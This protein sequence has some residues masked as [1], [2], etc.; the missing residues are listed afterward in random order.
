[1]K[2]KNMLKIV[3]LI[4]MILLDHSVRA[5]E[6]LSELEE[7]RFRRKS[8][9]KI[10]RGKR[11]GNGQLARPGRVAVTAPKGLPQVNNQQNQPTDNRDYE[12]MLNAKDR[13]LLIL[14]SEV[15][16][17]KPPADKDDGETQVFPQS[18]VAGT[19]FKWSFLWYTLMHFP[20]NNALKSDATYW[21]SEK[22][23]QHDHWEAIF[24]LPQKI[25][26]IEIHWRLAPKRFRVFFKLDDKDEYIPVTDVVQKTSFISKEGQIQDKDSYSPYNAVVFHKPIFAKRIRINLNE[27]IK[28]NSFSIFF[29]KFFQKKTTL[30]IKNELMDENQHWCFYV[31]TNYPIQDTKVE[32]YPCLQALALSNNNELWIHNTDS[33]IR[34]FNSNM[35]L[36]FDVENELVLRPCGVYKPAF[37]VQNRRD[38]TLFF[39]GYEKNCLVMDESKKVSGNFISE[40]TDII[41]TTQADGQTYK[42]ENVKFTGENIWHSAPGQ[43][44]ATVQI[45]F[46]KMKKGPQKGKYESKKIDLIKID[47]IKPPKKFMVYTWRPGFSWTLRH[48]Y[49]NYSEKNSEIR[50]VG[51]EASAIMLVLEQSHFYPEL[52]RMAGYAIREIIVTYNS[53]KL[54]NDNCSNYKESFKVF[55]FDTQGYHKLENTNEYNKVRQKLSTTFEKTV[56]NYNNIKKSK[57]YTQ[58]S[59]IQ[60]QGLLSKLNQVKSNIADKT[61]KNLRNF[62]SDILPKISNSVFLEQLRKKGPRIMENSI[63]KR[64]SSSNSSLGTK[65]TPGIDCLSIK[66]LKKNSLSG[67]YYIKNE[68]MPKPL[69]VFCDFTINEDATDILIFNDEQSEPNPDLNHLGIKD[70]NSVRYQCAKLGLTPLQINNANMVSRIYQVLELFG[71]DLAKPVAVPLGYDYTCQNGKCGGIINSLNDKQSSVISSFFAEAGK[72]G[73]SGLIVKPGP[74]AGLGYSNNHSMIKFDPAHVKITALICSTN[75]SKTDTTDSQVKTISCE[76]SP[77]NNI[78]LFAENSNILIEC[79]TACAQAS[80]PIYGTDV[81]H[82]K[83][84]VCKAAIHSQHLGALGGKIYVRVSKTNV[85]FLG[86]TRNGI[87]S[88][89]YNTQDGLASFS[90]IKYESKC[91]INQFTELA[92]KEKE[93][94]ANETDTK[95]DESS[96]NGENSSDSSPSSFLQTSTTIMLSQVKDKF[97]S[98]FNSSELDGVD[99]DDIKKAGLDVSTDALKSLNKSDD[100]KENYI[101]NQST[102]KLSESPVSENVSSTTIQGLNDGMLKDVNNLVSYNNENGMSNNQ[103]DINNVNYDQAENLPQGNENNYNFSELENENSSENTSEVENPDKRNKLTTEDSQSSMVSNL[104][105]NIKTAENT[106]Q[107]IA[108]KALNQAINP[109]ENTRVPPPSLPEAPRPKA[110]K[111]PEDEPQK[112]PTNKRPEPTTDDGKKIIMQIRKVVDSDY[113]DLLT[114]KNE[115]IKKLIS[116]FKKSL[117]WSMTGSSLSTVSLKSIN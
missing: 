110:T 25:D 8:F 84:S 18:A 31:N 81:Y 1:M 60:A 76:T 59:H 26:V 102:E 93:T 46:G 107:N 32:A 4:A 90:L 2:F 80:S 109:A 33:T 64:K 104:T 103:F 89:D 36:A 83:S 73:K 92:K 106:A 10:K 87:K 51:E 105:N 6:N 3:F 71:Y 17:A 111:P 108:N 14:N 101:Y 53:I 19:E 28:K 40:E 68:C 12:T 117:S 27:P 30:L 91:P 54:K 58:K 67:W 22:G 44:K 85:K 24:A 86:S 114:K 13:N 116:E 112:K 49:Q 7:R 66:K 98:D 47:W 34:H 100:D 45:L 82:I 115:K 74:F 50:I 29:V 20:A 42:K 97:E 113:I 37:T 61:I 69:L 65:S 11:P 56:A 99:V 52:G 77:I 39:T 41:I 15:L 94:Q 38:E 35:C 96:S 63:T 70:F 23:R 16:N 72:S 48:V 55:D 79:P 78:D 43:N 21:L 62:K 75:H 95:S 57:A 5:K 88:L 9:S